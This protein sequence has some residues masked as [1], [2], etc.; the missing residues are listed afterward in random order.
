MFCWILVA[1]VFQYSSCVRVLEL[2]IP[3]NIME[4]E[5]ATL[6]CNYDLQVITRNNRVEWEF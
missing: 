1:L 5:T 4:G 2:D 6:F 3:P